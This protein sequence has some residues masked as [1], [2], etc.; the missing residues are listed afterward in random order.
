MKVE[1]D[2]DDKARFV[3]D[4][5]TYAYNSLRE[6]T[7]KIIK[8]QFKL[9]LGYEFRELAK[10]TVNSILEEEK[11]DLKKI[12]K[13]LVIGSKMGLG[14]WYN[15]NTALDE[16][17]KFNLEKELKNLFVEDKEE[18]KQLFLGFLKERFFDF[19]K[20]KI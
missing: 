6:E 19:L 10:A 20:S 5:Q 2:D 13:D 18:M 9:L 15:L 16:Y 3:H 11:I 8:E 12:I 17:F 4:L 1:L 7:L 14:R